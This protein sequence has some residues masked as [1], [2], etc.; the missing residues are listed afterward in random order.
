MSKNPF[1]K[2]PV[3]NA[4]TAVLQCG[5]EILLLHRQPQLT[6][7]AGYYAF[8]GGKVDPGDEQLAPTDAIFDGLGPRLLGALARELK[9]EIDVSLGALADSGEILR[10]DTAGYALTPPIAPFRFGTHFYIIQLRSKPALTLD[11]REHSDAGWASAENWL[12]R[13]GQGRLL[14]AP[15]TLLALQDLAEHP[16]PVVLPRLE[17]MAD[18]SRFGDDS[19][20]E[21]QSLAGVRQLFV[22][23]N[24]IPPAAHTNCFLI[25][26]DGSP[27]LLVDPSPADDDEY[28]KLRTH[29]ADAFDVIFLTHHHGDH[30]ERADRLAREA[31][32]P[33]WLSTD[34][35][36]RITT[37]KPHFFDGLEVRE[38]GDGDAVTRWLGRAVNAHAIPGHDRGQLALMP[39]DRAWCIVG[40]LIQGI[41]TVVIAPPEGDMAEYFATMQKVID[42]NPAVIYP[43]H[44]TALGST[45][46]V[47]AVLAHRKQREAQI[48]TLHQAGKD[49]DQIL[50]S[51]YAGTPDHLL[52][53]ARINIQSHMTKLQAEQRLAPPSSTT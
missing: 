31:G 52:P 28:D 3:R 16:R 26:D 49:E 9:E 45:H 50:D 11:R 38:I 18:D 5:D 29:T 17:R 10:I 48:L 7:F 20:V 51:V 41:G 42:W 6:A 4:V 32:V 46:Y 15:P 27:R 43:S 2:A 1:T 34:T 13:Y 35:R 12:E 36:Q 22:R 40:D 44:G 47:Q 33:I 19:I 37:A 39:E 14:L 21:V 23:S 25:G 53:L 24:T 30:H 8:A